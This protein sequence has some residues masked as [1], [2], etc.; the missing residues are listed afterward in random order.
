[1]KTAYRVLAYL[2]ALAV[3]FQASAIAFGMFGFV[4]AME[5]GAVFGSDS[6]APNAGPAM[7]AVGGMMVIPALTILL[8]I[9]SFFAKVRGGTKWALLVLLVVAVQVNLGFFAFDLPAIGLL[10][11]VNAFVLLAVALVA[12]RKAGGTDVTHAAAVE[13]ASV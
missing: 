7:H 9:S 2:I 1:M 6:D 13:T 4:E 8:L 10:H 11:A 5:G 12:A 3:V